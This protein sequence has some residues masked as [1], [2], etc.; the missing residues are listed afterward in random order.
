MQNRAEIA[1]LSRLLGRLPEQLAYLQTIPSEDIGQLREQVTEVLFSS[2][3]TLGRLAASSKLLPIGVVATIAERVFGPVLSARV[4]GL[5]EPERA[6]QMAAK[7]PTEFLAD[8][9]VE[10]DPRRAHAVIARIPPEQ[11]A[12]ITRVLISRCEFVTMGRFVGHLDSVAVAAAVE[13]MDDSS[14]LQ[15]AFVLENPDGFRDLVGLL[16]SVRLEH[17]IDTAAAEALWPETLDLLTRIDDGERARM[18]EIAAGRQ[19]AVLDTLITSAQADGLWELVLPL[20]G[21]MSQKSLRR[22]ATLRSLQGAG[23]LESI[24]DAAVEHPDLWHNLVPIV[25]FLPE[26]CQARVAQHVGG[27]PIDRALLIE[28]AREAGVADLLGPLGAVLSA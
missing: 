19:D 8:I 25:A 4:A 6:V 15:V 26:A 5:L 7:L 27:L 18:I 17:V 12:A 23:V 2:N 24:V 3:G 10:L 22:F 16:S 11:I 1:K 21:L 28:H 9:A 14:M 13:A 20:T